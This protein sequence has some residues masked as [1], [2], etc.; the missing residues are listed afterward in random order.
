M[1]T[2]GCSQLDMFGFI[3]LI[4]LFDLLENKIQI[5]KTF[6]F[7]DDLARIFEVHHK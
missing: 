1:Q 4:S 7:D 3:A 5:E 2:K 6:V